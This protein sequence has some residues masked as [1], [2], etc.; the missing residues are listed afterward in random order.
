MV[1]ELA[2]GSGSSSIDSDDTGDPRNQWELYP[3]RNWRGFQ[4]SSL[5]CTGLI[6]NFVF[7]LDGHIFL[8]YNS[9]SKTEY[10]RGGGALLSAGCFSSEHDIF[11]EE[12]PQGCWYCPE[13]RPFF[14]SLS[15]VT[16]ECSAA[17]KNKQLASSNDSGN[18]FLEVLSV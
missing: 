16:V 10:S 1:N 6:Y 3:S 5:V 12:P 2:D 8:D 4:A 13:V 18:F 9:Y 7:V 14:S 17:S 11:Y 15:E